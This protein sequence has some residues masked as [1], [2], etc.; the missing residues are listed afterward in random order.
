MEN[1]TDA[2]AT[3]IVAIIEAATKLTLEN[4][5]IDLEA[6]VQYVDLYQLYSNYYHHIMQHL[7]LL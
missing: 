7:P 3:I 6:R 5:R 1:Y 4:A 2:Q